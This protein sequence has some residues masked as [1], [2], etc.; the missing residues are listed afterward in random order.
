MI[1]LTEQNSLC[2]TQFDVITKNI[3][4]TQAAIL[5][6][7]R[8]ASEQS[9]TWNTQLDNFYHFLLLIHLQ[10]RAKSIVDNNKGKSPSF[11]HKLFNQT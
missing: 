5:Q 1:S 9:A 3:K 11:L 7:H 4:V 6:F 10:E 2:H 8:A